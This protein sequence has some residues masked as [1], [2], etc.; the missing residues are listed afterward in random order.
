MK[1]GRGCWWRGRNESSFR[2]YQK[3]KTVSLFSQPKFA[4]AVAAKKLPQKAHPMPWCTC[5]KQR[6][7][8]CLFVGM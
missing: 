3:Y 2:R 4:A 1:V 8:G 7:K 5:N 6:E